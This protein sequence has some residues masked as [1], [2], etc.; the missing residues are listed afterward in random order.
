MCNINI[1]FTDLIQ[2]R[3]GCM[4]CMDF[5]IFAN[6]RYVRLVRSF[7]AIAH[8]LHIHLLEL[9]R[10]G[11][12]L[13]EGYMFGFSYGGRLV[14]EAAKRLGTRIIKDID[15]W[16]AHFMFEKIGM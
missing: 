10:I 7:D 14:C 4:I 6:D 3:G 2:H 8:I 13:R 11:F 5:S 12:N 15:G 1:L 16:Y 9:E